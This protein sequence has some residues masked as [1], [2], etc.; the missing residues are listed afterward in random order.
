M[1][2]TSYILIV[3]SGF[4]LNFLP[5]SPIYLFFF[6]SLIGVFLYS[7]KNQ[8]LHFNHLTGLTLILLGYLIITQI[9]INE[10]K[11]NAIYNVIISLIYFILTFASIHKLETEKIIK[12]SKSFINVSILLLIVEAIWRISHPWYPTTL[13]YMTQ[14]DSSFYKYKMNSI[15][16]QDSNFVGIFIISLFFFCVYLKLNHAIT[17]RWQMIVLASLCGLTFSRAAII[18]LVAFYILLGIRSK[19]MKGLMILLSMLFGFVF[20]INY[21]DDDISFLSKLDIIDRTITFM[22]HASISEIAIGIGFGNAFK[23]LQI[24]AHNFIV[25]YLIESGVIGLFLLLLLWWKILRSTKFKAGIIM[26]PFLVSGMSLAGH[27]I[28]YLYCIFAIIYILEKRKEIS[29]DVVS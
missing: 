26:I 14:V 6:L 24:G 17:L 2:R 9:M 11:T 15:M 29:M 5:V 25:T 27:A 19:A 13:W 23:Y 1:Y 10:D 21:I 16:Y 18:T 8:E 3:F 22:K 7:L 20:L 28:T 12:I 4:F